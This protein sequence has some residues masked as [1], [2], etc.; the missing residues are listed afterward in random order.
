VRPWYFVFLV[1]IH[2]LFSALLEKK[3]SFNYGIA[4]ECLW[5]GICKFHTK[6]LLKFMFVV[7]VVGTVFRTAL[8]LE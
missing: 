8:A 6:L 2:T 7:Y 5:F 3:F 4:G 1:E